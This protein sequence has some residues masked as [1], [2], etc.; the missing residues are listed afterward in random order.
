MKL[1]EIRN[2]KIVRTMLGF[3]DHGIM[4]AMLDTRS[5]ALGQGFGGYGMDGKW[6]MEFIKRVLKTLDV[7][8]WEQLEGTHCRIDADH[9]HVYRIGHIIEDK[10]FDPK[11]DLKE[12]EVQK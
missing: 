6:G 7:E 5:G 8:T 1:G 11:V 3:E 12:F 2:A 4:T 9:S 10:W